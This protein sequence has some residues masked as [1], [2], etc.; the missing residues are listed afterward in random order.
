[1]GLKK[2]L[3]KLVKN[4]GTTI[5]KVVVQPAK[6]AADAVGDVIEDVVDFA[7]DVGDDAVK[8]ID[9]AGEDFAKFVCGL[10]GKEPGQGCNVSAGVSVNSK[11][12]I[13]LTDGEGNPSGVPPADNSDFDLSISNVWTWSKEQELNAFLNAEEWTFRDSLDEMTVT[14]GFGMRT[15]NGVEKFHGAVDLRARTPQPVYSAGPGV[16]IHA[17]PVDKY[18]NAGITVTIRHP[19]SIEVQFMH[20]SETRVKVGDVVSGKAVVAL[21]GETGSAKGQPHLHVVVKTGGARQDP[22]LMY[23]RKIPKGTTVVEKQ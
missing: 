1:M 23:G 10:V 11:E 21:T 2:K 19:H 22:M 6:K 14:S 18:P 5:K 20:L 15:I 8:V 7:D 13:V 9:E 16:I 3:K 4:P 17:G 12:D